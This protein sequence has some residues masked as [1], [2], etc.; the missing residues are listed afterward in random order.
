VPLAGV[1]PDQPV[2]AMAVAPARPARPHHDILELKQAGL[3]DEFILNKI[4]TD[5]VNYQLTTADIIEL[6]RAGLSEAILEAMLRSG[7]SRPPAR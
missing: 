5:N 2:V 4:R 7:Q 6:R 3:S 1:V